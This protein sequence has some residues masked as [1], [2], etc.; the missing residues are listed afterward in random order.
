MERNLRRARVKWVWMVSI[1]GREG[2]DRRTAVRFYVAVLQVV[3]LF[4]SET[5]V[6]TPWLEKAL[7]RFHHQEVLRM[8][9]MC[10]T[11][12]LYGAWV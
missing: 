1:L 8:G 2:A 4:G 7:L 5:W 11:C 10:P 9:G 12:Q 3:L 6:A